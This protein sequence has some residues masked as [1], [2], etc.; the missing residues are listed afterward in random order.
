[1][2]NPTPPPA[3]LIDRIGALP[4]EQAITTLALV[5]QRQG[6]TV[7][8]FTWADT[9]AHLRE[10]LT[11]PDIRDVA[12]PDLDATPGALARTTLTYLAHTDDTTHDLI[13]HAVTIAPRPERFDPATLIIGALVL[14]A[15]HADI[16]LAHDP[17]KGWTFHF[18]TT[19]LLPDT[20]GT[21]LG[22]LY[23]TYLDPKN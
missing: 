21:I 16:N 8:P 18:R 15:F 22:Q 2:T 17:E 5:L 23:G 10:A 9:E 7:D 20:I 12:D 19:A 4:D 6:R 11:Q 1:M 13:E 14:L 3:A